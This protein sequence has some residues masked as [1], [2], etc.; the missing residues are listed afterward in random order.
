MKRRAYLGLIGAGVLAGCSGDGS[1]DGGDGGTDEADGTG[2]TTGGAAT[3]EPTDATTDGADTTEPTD[4]TTD[5]STTT[6]ANQSSVSFDD[7]WNVDLRREFDFDEQISGANFG[8]D[9][10]P[11]GVFVGAD[12]GF[13]ALGLDEGELT[14]SKE[15]WDGFVDVHADADGVVAYTN[16]FEVAAFD[17]ASG[18]ERW[19]TAASEPENAIPHSA[20]TP[21]YF[22]A[23]TADGIVVHDRAAGE[24]VTTIDASAQWLVASDEVVVTLNGQETVAYDAESGSERWRTGTFLVPG[25]VLHQDRVVGLDPGGPDEE[26]ALLALDAASGDRVWSESAGD[27]SIGGA[28]IAVEGDVAAFLSGGI[29]EESTLFAHGLSD[30]SQLWTENLGNVGTSGFSPPATDSGVVIAP[31]L[32]DDNRS[33]TRAYGARSGEQLDETGGGLGIAE[34]LAVERVFLEIGLSDVAAIGF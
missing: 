27:V 4:A 33:L 5:G 15:E 19:R 11:D 16:S 9:A 14:W 23:R 18:T 34:G 28:G 1:G 17:P 10:T 6:T 21:S 31:A 2:A 26:G 20:L 13:A 3:T 7:R 22:V 24:T 12:W 8:A 32:S 25:A 30:G 29:G